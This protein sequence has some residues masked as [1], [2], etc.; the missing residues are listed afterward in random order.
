MNNKLALIVVI[1][2]ALTSGGCSSL[3]NDIGSMNANW[4]N[5]PA[6]VTCWSGGK[7]IY[8]TTTTGKVTTG[9]GDMATFWD[10]D[11]NL[12]EM[13]ADCSFVYDTK[14]SAKTT[15]TVSPNSTPPNTPTSN[16]GVNPIT[17][18]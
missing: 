7:V 1:V 17:G 12:V 2:A 11:G 8:Q 4:T 9:T 13:F 5:K 3:Q 15:P 16:K 14:P 18:R 10:A 6:T